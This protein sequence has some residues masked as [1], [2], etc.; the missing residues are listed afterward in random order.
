MLQ[1][2]AAVAAELAG[3]IGRQTLCQGVAFRPE[4]LR[5]FDVSLEPEKRSPALVI[6]KVALLRFRILEPLTGP[7]RDRQVYRKL[8][9]S[10]SD[11]TGAVTAGVSIAVFSNSKQSRWKS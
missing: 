8:G 3:S 6:V 7:G 9:T 1:E 11:S 5:D 10:A 2:F 4:R